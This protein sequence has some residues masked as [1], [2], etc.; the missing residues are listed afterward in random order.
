MNPKRYALR[1]DEELWS[2]LEKWLDIERQKNPMQHN[3]SM[4]D[5]LR[6]ILIKYVADRE[7]QAG[8][9]RTKNSK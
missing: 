6:A 4:H 9:K 8:A 3:I 5:F 2:Q 7:Y 1:L